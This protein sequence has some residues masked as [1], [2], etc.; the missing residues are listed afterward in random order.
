MVCKENKERKP[1]ENNL[2]RSIHHHHQ[3]QQ[4]QQ[5][6]GASCEINCNIK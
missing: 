2:N 1:L 4:Q 5:Q 3:Q 6:E